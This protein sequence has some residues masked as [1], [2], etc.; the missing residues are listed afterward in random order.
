M[1]SKH[2][3]RVDALSRFRILSFDDWS[4]EHFKNVS[5]VPATVMAEGYDAY[6]INKHNEKARLA[7]LVQYGG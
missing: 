4:K 2:Q 7:E 5:K 3:R 6:L 1:K